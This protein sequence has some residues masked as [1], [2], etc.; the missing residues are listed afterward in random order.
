MVWSVIIILYA[1]AALQVWVE[2]KSLLYE[3]WS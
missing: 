2:S 1:S 3:W